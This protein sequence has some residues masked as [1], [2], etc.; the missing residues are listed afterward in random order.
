[1]PANDAAI[2]LEPGRPV[3]L[4]VEEGQD[5][6]NFAVFSRH[7]ERVELLIFDE[8]DSESPIAAFDLQSAAHRTGDVWHAFV[9]GLR[10]GQAYAYRVWGPWAPDHGH[11][12]DSSRIL[13]DPRALAVVLPKEVGPARPHAADRRTRTQSGGRALLIDRRFDWQ[14]TVPART[15]WSDTVIYET[16][17]RGLTMHPSAKVAHPGTFLGVVEKIPYFRELGVTALELMPVQAFDD[18][19]ALRVE[20]AS[21]APLRNYWGYDTVAFFAPHGTYSTRS[22]P[23]AEV[24]EFKTMVRELHRNGIEV[25]LDIV[26]SHTAEGGEAGPLFNFRGFDNAIYYM[27]QEDKAAY[28]NYSGCGNT[29]NCNHPVVREFIIDCLRYWV[30]DMHVDG[31][32]FDLA[33]ILGRD[34]HGRLVSNPPLLESIADDPILRQVKLIAEAWD[35]GGAYQVGSFPGQRWAEWNA[36]F[37]DDV[38]RFWRGDAGMTGA[39]AKRLCGSA[40]LYQHHGK[41]PV[42][43]V[44]FVA[45]HD[46]FTLRDVVSYAHKHNWENGENG[47]DGAND[48]SSANYGFEGV[49]CDA[50]IQQTRLRQ[51]KNMLALLLLSRGVPMLLGGDEFCRTQNGNNNP[52]CQDNVLSWYDWGLL[53]RNREMHRFVC[54]LVAL[55]KRHPVLSRDAFYTDADIEWFGAAGEAPDWNGPARVLGCVIK[56]ARTAGVHEPAAT[57]CLLVNGANAPVEFALPAAPAA[58]WRIVV[59]TGRAA[60]GEIWPA[61]DE[62]PVHD[63]A[64]H[65]LA[66]RSLA[67]LLS[68]PAAPNGRASID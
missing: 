34:E 60:P 10:Y 37:R 2:R 33:S 54:E 20:P 7:A 24:S 1:M 28:R 15:P 39:L 16:H 23:G 68:A 21:G 14:G 26:L 55:R 9:T 45:C 64:R 57:L 62:V 63:D 5:G 38:R 12:F 4:G 65:G 59:D 3:P 50:K 19:R 52:Y 35:M 29:F 42:N 61:D 17:V 36:R 31:F 46:G 58:P 6:F 25:I 49:T 66:E 40:D 22:A 41:E 8:A 48:D 51:N 53:E 11:R 44:N 18:V 56:P 67:L 27:L 43:S 30:A 13:I 32:R 47:L